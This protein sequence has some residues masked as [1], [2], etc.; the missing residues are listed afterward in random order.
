[1]LIESIICKEKAPLQ[2]IRD[3]TVL[4]MNKSDRVDFVHRC[5]HR[6]FSFLNRGHSW[7]EKSPKG[8]F[9]KVPETD[10]TISYSRHL[11]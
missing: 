4:Q 11:R 7:T 5:C 8:S 3:P 1:M 2:I 6:P 10:S 9:R